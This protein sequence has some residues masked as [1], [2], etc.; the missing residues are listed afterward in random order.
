M[1]NLIP[2]PASV[3]QSG[4]AFTWTAGAGIYV[5]PATVEMVQIGEYLA[6][7]VNP[8]TGLRLRVVAGAPP[9]PASG[10]LYLTTVGADPELGEEGYEVIVTPE[11]V[12]VVAPEPAGVFWGVQTLRQMLPAAMEGAGRQAGPRCLATGRIRDWP[13]FGWRGMMLDVARHFFGVEEVKRLIDLMALYK[14]NRLHLH[15]TDDQGWRIAIESWPNLAAYGGSTQVGGGPGGYYTQAEYA[16]MVRYAASRYIVVVPEIEM[17]GHTNA[18]LA[19]YA[20]LNCD[21]VAPPLY[22]GTEVGMSS[23]C[24]GKEITLAFVEDVVREISALTPGPYVHIGGDE[25]WSTKEEDYVEFIGRVQEIVRSYGKQ[26][27]GYEEI[28][29]AKLLPTS[30]AQH[31]ASDL[32][33]KAVEQGAKAILSPATRSYLDM[34]YVEATPLGLNWAG[35]VEVQDAY[36]WDPATQVE[37]VAEEDVVGV[38]ALLWTETVETMDDIEYMTFPRLAGLAEIGWSPAAGRSW[39]EYRLR[40][41]AQGPRW[42]AMGVNF[43]RSGQVPW[44]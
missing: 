9:S 30:I 5:E 20:E 19:S 28:G 4:G 41:G 16:E 40:L 8:P 18:A 14:L 15:L 13:R 22:T 21:G 43:H 31:W 38:E 34:K 12:R 7:K 37:G 44:G 36:D 32:V 17:P 1:E 42:R 29:R 26:T 33:R 6:D 27:V 2:M 23:L 25:T 39:E 11:G 35:C 3:T 10:T 24:I